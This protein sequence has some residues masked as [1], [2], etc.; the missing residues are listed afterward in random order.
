MQFA[1]RARDVGGNLRQGELAASTAQEAGRLLRQE[2]MF[3]VSLNEADEA[4]NTVSFSLFQKRVSRSEIVDVTNQMAV[5]IDAGVPL[6]TALLSVTS[7]TENSTLREILDKITNDVEAGDSFSTALGRFPKLFDRTYVNLV[8]ASEASGTLG[9]M[10]GRIA[11]QSINEQEV[12]QKVRGA[13]TYPAVMLV[14]C[15]AVCIFLLAYV[16][17]K[18]TPMFASRNIDIPTPTRVIMFVSSL[19]VDHTLL[20][21]GTTAALVAA[22][23]YVLRQPWGRRALDWTWLNLPVVGPMVRKVIIGRTLRTLATTINAGVPMLDSLKLSASVTNN[24]YYEECWLGVGQQVST[25]RQIHEALEDEKLI[26]TTLVQMIAS[27]ES[28]GKLGQVL[29]KVS[30][31]YEREVGAAIKTATGL[32]EPLMVMT[33]GGL[34]G[35]IA[36]AMLLPIFK[37]SQSI[38]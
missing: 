25:G 2:G 35:G 17:P 31:H 8:K 14:M 1:Y 5:M 29:S 30:D 16:F 11:E 3:L 6:S 10:L 28:T 18:L 21:V 27:G 15:I 20:I 9:S 12:R 32:I 7:Q 24:V 19:L 38:G 22:I 26:P 34:I 36:L 4:P 23:I 33:M 13:M 37:L